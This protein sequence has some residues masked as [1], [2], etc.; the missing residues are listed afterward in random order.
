MLFYHQALVC[1][2]IYGMYTVWNH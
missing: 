1:Q 2:I